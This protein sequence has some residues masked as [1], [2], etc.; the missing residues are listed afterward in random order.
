MPPFRASSVSLILRGTISFVAQDYAPISSNSPPPYPTIP[1]QYPPLLDEVSPTSTPRSGAPYQPPKSSLCPLQQVTEREGETIKVYATFS[2]SNLALC[3]GK[4]GQFSEDPGKFVEEIIKL[5]MSFDLTWHDMQ[6][7]CACCTIEEIQ[8][9][10]GAIHECAAGI[11][12]CNPGHDIYC[13]EAD[14]VPDLAPQ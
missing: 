12:T 3:K 1:D 5:T 11:A 13:V 2:M 14:A 8:I 6:I 7:L 4:F 10:L 9:I